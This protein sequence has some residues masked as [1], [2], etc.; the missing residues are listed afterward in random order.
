VERGDE[1][2]SVVGGGGGGGGG[3]RSCS[4]KHLRSSAG[5]RWDSLF[6]KRGESARD[7][8][9]GGTLKTAIESIRR[10]ESSR[11][12]VTCSS[13]GRKAKVEGKLGCEKTLLDAAK[14]LKNEKGTA[15]QDIQF[16][17]YEPWE[18]TDGRRVE[19]DLV[20]GERGSQQETTKN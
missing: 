1:A 11:I 4:I 19:I 18:D 15:A 9:G 2:L 10:I 5:S 8:E 17:H 7:G 13:S 6:L 3:R 20:S 14:Q 12:S 16:E